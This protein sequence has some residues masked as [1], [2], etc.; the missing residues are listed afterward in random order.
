ML[1]LPIPE[2][3]LTAAQTQSADSTGVIIGF[4][5]AGVVMFFWQFAVILKLAHEV[6]EVRRILLRALEVEP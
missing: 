2:G 6:N 4:L 3:M 5:A 1:N